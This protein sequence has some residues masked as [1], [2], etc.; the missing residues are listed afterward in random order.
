MIYKK[1]A[2]FPYPVLTNTTTTYS[3][4]YFTVDIALEENTNHY[5]FVLDYEIS[6]AFIQECIRTQKADVVFIVQSKDT[7][8]V[9]LSPNQRTVDIE[10][11]RIS[12]NK[13]TSIQLQIQTNEAITFAENDDL[14]AFYDPFKSE[15]ELQKNQ[16]LGFSNVV[17]FE[18][19]I[20]NPLVL[21][22]KKLDESLT[23]DIKVELGT[24]TIIIHYKKADYQF[25]GMRHSR[26]FNTPFLYMGLQ[27]ALQ[28]FI[29]VH[30]KED[31]DS[32]ELLD[33][34]IPENGLDFKLYNLMR[35][36]M[37]TELSNENIDEVIA[38]ISEKMIE[39]YSLAVRELDRDGD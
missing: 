24:E 35:K 14:A 20:Q 26:D 22:E 3:N 19:S 23:S 18:G 9:K 37:V 11:S 17:V 12:L 10:K 15:I 29:V 38:L 39:K 8:F 1:D 6:S 36:K 33:C 31:E 2:N 21:F 5:R 30:S 16:T 27:K 4:P 28:Q 32:V 25:N 13:R 7:R 34:E